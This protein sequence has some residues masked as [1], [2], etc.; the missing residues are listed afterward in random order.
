MKLECENC[1]KIIEVE[2]NE[3]LVYC[4]HCG[5]K[6]YIF[7]D[8]EDRI[9]YICKLVKEQNYREADSLIDIIRKSSLHKWEINI[10]EAIIYYGMDKECTLIINTIYNAFKE[11]ESDNTI[12]P[13]MVNKFKVF[14][15]KALKIISQEAFNEQKIFYDKEFYESN[16]IDKDA[17]YSGA[18]MKTLQECINRTVNDMIQ[19][20]D[21]A[22]YSLYLIHNISDVECLQL[23]IDLIKDILLD[24]KYLCGH[25]KFFNVYLMDYMYQGL[26]VEEKQT[27]VNNY[28][29]LVSIL[30]LYDNKFE[31]TDSMLIDPL[32]P[33]DF[34]DNDSRKNLS[35]STINRNLSMLKNYSEENLFTKLFNDE[36]IEEITDYFYVSSTFEMSKDLDNSIKYANLLEESRKKYDFIEVID[37]CIEASNI[38][39][40]HYLAYHHLIYAYLGTGNIKMLLKAFKDFIRCVENSN[41]DFCKEEINSLV[42]SVA[43]GS[44][45]TFLHIACDANDYEVAKFLLENGANP[46]ALSKEQF[47]PMDVIYIKADEENNKEKFRQ[48][49]NLLSSYGAELN[50]IPKETKIFEPIQKYSTKTIN[51]SETYKPK[52]KVASNKKSNKKSDLV[53]KRLKSYEEYL[54]TGYIDEDEF[55]EHGD[56]STIDSLKVLLV[57]SAIAVVAFLFTRGLLRIVILIV[58]IFLIWASISTIR[59]NKEKKEKYIN[60]LKEF[61][62]E[63][64]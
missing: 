43:Q 62:S 1:H 33:K 60:F 11:S 64:K 22:L 42:S 34:S 19:I 47:S 17:N 50:L 52:E 21:V 29:L 7:Q 2:E 28:Y 12:E 63:Y 30:K 57:S 18:T 44:N 38:Y 6:M 54:S 31:I 14:V 32:D 59:E 24:T 26:N 15:A 46:N 10:L 58:M 4:K 13:A 49:Y 25:Y 45:F 39:K 8:I 3:N 37:T 16:S 53:R 5:Q 40:N 48:L 41:S 23:K 20:Y 56:L 35:S 61:Y 55:L 36:Y 27:F 9:K 51:K